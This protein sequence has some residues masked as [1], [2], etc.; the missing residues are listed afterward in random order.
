MKT[1]M[2]GIALVLIL[3]SC[4]A[5][6]YRAEADRFLAG[7]PE[8]LQDR[9]NDAILAA[10]AGDTA[11][12][13]A[14]RSARNT[15]AE[16]PAGVTARDVGEGL[17][18]YLPATP[19]QESL[20]L[21]VYLHGGGWTIGSINSC[22]RYCIALAE[23]GVAVL[24]VDYR[25]APEYPYPV[26]LNDCA[27][28]VETAFRCAKEWGVDPGRI[29]VGGDS[30]G[31]NL[32]LAVAL[33]KPSRLSSL[34]VFYPVVRAWNDGSQSWLRYRGG[35]ALDG[36]IMETFNRSYIQDTEQCAEISPALAADDALRML[37]PILMVA[38]E[39]DI[40]YD[41][42]RDFAQRVSA[43][44]V[45]VEHHTFRG[46]VHLF[47]TVAGQEAAFRAAV[48]RSARWLLGE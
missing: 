22:A 20:P 31:G 38:A 17:R 28:A 42:G 32:A 36:K 39:R 13:T 29:S 34:V 47:I 30:S 41:Q 14:V 10:L 27:D 3:T 18:L 11:P 15:P 6:D 44:G 9:Q 23:R 12:L 26:P 46:A 40:L 16:L 25:L 19:P 7:M 1:L 43:L 48:D 2:W 45:R 5:Q 33:R 8:G 4:S 35:M 37:P 24:A 21:L